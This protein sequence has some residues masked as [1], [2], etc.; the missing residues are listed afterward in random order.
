[1]RCYFSTV[2]KAKV[3]LLGFLVGLI[4]TILLNSW[5]AEQKDYYPSP[6]TNDCY[7]TLTSPAIFNNLND[8]Y[9]KKEESVALELARKVRI[10]CWVMTHPVTLYKN[11]KAARDTWG[12]RCNIILFMSSVQDDCFPA[13]GLGVAEGRENLWL[14]TRAAW[15]YI[16]ENHFN[17]AEWFIKVDDDA[18]VVLENLRLFL[19]PHRTTDPHYFGRHFQTFKGYNSGGAGYVFSK[20]T[21]RRFVRVMKD[22]FLCKEVSDFEDKEIGVCLSAVGIYPEETRDIK[23]RETFHPFH[24]LVH[25]MPGLIKSNNWLYQYSKWEVR[26]GPECCSD[27]SIAF[28]YI[29]PNDMYFLNFVLYQVHPF[30]ISHSNVLNYHV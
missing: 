2:N 14:K 26:I 11:A 10:L 29:R 30:G 23:G 20:E 16:F 17:D 27:N 24:P 8:L 6:T 21:L 18:F 13:V 1:M 4:I 3:F 22:P 25:V 5:L 28:H 19:N 15:K 12:K 7:K 9:S